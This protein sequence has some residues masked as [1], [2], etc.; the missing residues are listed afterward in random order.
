MVIDIPTILNEEEVKLAKKQLL[1]DEEIYQISDF[2]KI[3]GDST[4]LKL[5]WAL[6]SKELCVGDLCNVLNMTKS[7]ISHQ[8]KSLKAAN[9]VKY[10]KVGK[11]VLYSLSDNHVRIIIE[12]AREHLE[13]K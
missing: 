5:L 7:A 13:E 8:L 12:T 10:R 4:R 1:K 3:F 2:F 9:L 11:N 6:D